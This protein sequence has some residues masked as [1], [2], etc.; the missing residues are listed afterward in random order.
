[1]GEMDKREGTMLPGQRTESTLLPLE[2]A[3]APKD[4]WKLFISVK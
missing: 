3:P 1:M 4:S 2:V